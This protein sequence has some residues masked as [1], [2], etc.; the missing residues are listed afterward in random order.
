MKQVLK[1]KKR[2]I[3]IF[4]IA[5]SKGGK[6]KYPLGQNSNWDPNPKLGANVDIYWRKSL[7]SSSLYVF[8]AVGKRPKPYLY[9]YLTRSPNPDSTP[10]LSDQLFQSIGVASW[11]NSNYTALTI[12][13][14]SFN[15]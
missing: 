14:F 8:L 10:I 12:D 6:R 7:S 2:I 3:C 5:S 11:A 4:Q 15:I 13:T 9:L 1:K